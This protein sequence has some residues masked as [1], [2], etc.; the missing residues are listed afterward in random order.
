MATTY[1]EFGAAY[2]SDN[3]I[4][5]HVLMPN[6]SEELAV[7]STAAVT[8]ASATPTAA[9]LMGVARVTTD[10]DI[11]LVSGAD[12]DPSTAPRRV[13]LAGG[14]IDLLVPAGHKIAVKALD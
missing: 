10:S 9:A 3:A 12:P 14:S 2:A 1:V 8:S 11:W 4:A 6:A 13:L 7:S 5:L